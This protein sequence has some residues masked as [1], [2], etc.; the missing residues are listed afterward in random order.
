M[1][2]L[3]TLRLKNIGRFVTEQVIDFTTLDGIIQ[4]DGLN[5]NT[6]GSSASA[7][8]TLFLALDYLLGI[9][10]TPVTILQSRL[11]KEGIWVQ[12]EFD[13]DGVPV[14]IERSKKGLS[15]VDGTDIIKGS[16]KLAEERL[17]KILG[18]SPALFRVLLHKRQKE[19]GFFLNFTPKQVHEFLVDA[20]NL[21]D[22]TAKA[23]LIDKDLTKLQ[24]LKDHANNSL[25]AAN[26]GLQSTL[27]ALSTI[28]LP[29]EPSIYTEAFIA[30][31]GTTV[32]LYTKQLNEQE[33]RQAQEREQLTRYKPDLSFKPFDRS[34][35]QGI[36]KEMANLMA[37]IF[38]LEKREK[39]RQNN[40]KDQI[41]ALRIKIIN[42][43]SI[44]DK[45]KKSHDEL[46]KIVLE[47]KRLGEGFCPTCSQGWITESAKEKESQLLQSFEAQKLI[48]GAG[49]VA[50][51][52]VKTLENE[53]EAFTPQ[54]VPVYPL[55]EMK[56]IDF[57]VQKLKMDLAFARG[58]EVDYNLQ[59]NEANKAKQDDYLAQLKTQ[60]D[61]HAAE[62]TALKDEIFK[63]KQ[64]LNAAVS[65][66]TTAKM[67]GSRYQTTLDNLKVQENKRRAD[68]ATANKALETLKESEELI[69]EAKMLV[70]SF[71]S[72][73]FD[74]ALESI[75]DKA[76]TIVRGIPNM[77]TATIQLEG[78]RETK[79]GTVR[80]EVTAVLSIDGEQGVPIKSLSGG[81]RSAMDLAIDLAVIDFLESETGKGMNIFILD[82]PFTGLG[83]AEIEPIL[84]L[85]QNSNLS[86]KIIIVDHNE[87]VKQSISNKITVVRTGEFSQ[88]EMGI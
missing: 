63:L 71:V 39:A 29:P 56:D 57:Q 20:K 83:P 58:H 37:Q 27:D 30:T 32:E 85:L 16:N 9:N 49:V 24:A 45:G 52:E 8:T 67:S 61:R 10:D 43:K 68:I 75:G 34:Q 47:L 33:F 44:V 69:S 6:G 64:Q 17:L 15:I 46:N 60:S 13:N 18:M 4:V 21:K 36:E 25:Q 66:F 70:K 84:E 40:V 51:L 74:E 2:K 35:I 41:N 53:I 54:M 79:E 12:G 59:Q 48:L 86:K 78:T 14:I 77:Q 38:D 22:Y 88:V 11:T 76:T 19:G 87:I 42:A 55:P 3:N 28:G 5:N 23:D 65:D 80:E 72:C 31:M 7:K 82:E 62:L 1:L 26:S 50:S 73:S 81:E